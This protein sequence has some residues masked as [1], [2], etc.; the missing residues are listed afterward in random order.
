MRAGPCSGSTKYSYP[1]LQTLF[2][3]P[4]KSP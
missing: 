3:S 4:K 1:V 2:N